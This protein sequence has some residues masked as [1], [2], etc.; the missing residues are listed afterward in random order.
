[1]L[2]QPP[3]HFLNSGCNSLILEETSYDLEMM[4]TEYE[5]LISH[6]NPDQLKV[7]HAVMDS[8]EKNAGGVFLCM[9]VVV[10]GRHICGR[11]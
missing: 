4:R 9:V 11:P 2:P 8:V 10:V 1:M 7:Y 3:S 6:C 5:D